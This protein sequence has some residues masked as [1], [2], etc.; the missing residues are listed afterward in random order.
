MRGEFVCN[1]EPDGHPIARADRKPH[2]SSNSDANNCTVTGANSFADAYFANAISAS[3]GR[4][5]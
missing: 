4:R 2:T 1:N 5:R 3:L